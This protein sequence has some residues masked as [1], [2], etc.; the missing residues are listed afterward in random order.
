MQEN[1]DNTNGYYGGKETYPDNGVSNVVYVHGT[2]DPWHQMGIYEGPMSEE[3]PYILIE[4]S[5][6]CADMY[7]EDSYITSPEL[8]EARARIKSYVATWLGEY[9]P[10]SPSK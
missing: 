8:E 1:M 5:S 6:H 3:A 2:V 9:T 7:E 10:T 4:G